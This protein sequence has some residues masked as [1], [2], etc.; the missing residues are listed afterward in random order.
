MFQRILDNFDIDT[1]GWFDT[2]E[3]VAKRNLLNR[4]SEITNKIWSLWASRPIRVHYVYLDT[5]E[6]LSIT[7]AIDAFAGHMD[8]YVADW[9]RQPSASEKIDIVNNF[10]NAYRHGD[11]WDNPNTPYDPMSDQ[12]PG[13]YIPGSLISD[14]MLDHVPDIYTLADAIT[15]YG[16]ESM[17]RDNACL[18]IGYDGLMF[19]ADALKSSNLPPNSSNITDPRSVHA[20]CMLDIWYAACVRD[21]RNKILTQWPGWHSIF[22]AQD[23]VLLPPTD[24][25]ASAVKVKSKY[26]SELRRFC[27][28]LAWNLNAAPDQRI[29]F[30]KQFKSAYDLAVQAWPGILSKCRTNEDHIFAINQLVHDLARILSPHEEKPKRSTTPRR[31]SSGLGIDG[32]PDK[33]ESFHRRQHVSGDSVIEPSTEEPDAVPTDSPCVGIPPPSIFYDMMTEEQMAPVLARNPKLREYAAKSKHLQDKVRAPIAEAISAA[34]WHVPTPPPTDHAQLQGVL[35]EGSLLNLAAFNDP[36]IFSVP[37]EAGHG[38]IAIAVVLDSSS[39]MSLNVYPTEIDPSTN[40]YEPSHNVMQEALAFLAG[41]KDGLA[42]ASNVSLSSFAYFGGCVADDS[43][44]ILHTKSDPSADS[45]LSVCNMRRLDTD[46]ALLYSYP[47]GGT[48]S[49]T[50]I[51]SASDY[52]FAHHPDA[53]KII[54]HLT[55]GAPCGGVED[56]YHNQESFDDGIS[57]VRHIVDNIPIPVFTV[58]FGFGIDAQTLRQQ[59]NHDKWFKVESPL[60]AVPVACQLITGI[61]QCLA[62]Q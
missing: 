14:R 33:D 57:S 39:S 34:A 12:G 48:P 44:Y 61:G 52:L 19:V 30:P 11:I 51:K 22:E 2:D 35:D 20:D 9:R 41:L 3:G 37:P 5:I 1:S 27:M 17:E 32:T 21:I 49:A 47:M 60:D 13:I 56:P 53:T 10:I 46:S 29:P 8:R 54:I 26:R 24:E 16:L 31:G 42:R 59:Y 18:N 38:Q 40:R 50:A 55:D 62:N 45:S 23:S 4:T 28:A 58:G 15:G 6:R 25:V 7:S 43:D 36:R